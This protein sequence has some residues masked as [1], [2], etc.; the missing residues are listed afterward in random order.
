MRRI[1][2]A[3]PFV[4]LATAA[5]ANTVDCG[6]NSFS[7]AEVRTHPRGARSKGPAQ[8]V[9][10]SLCANLIE[11]RRGSIRSLDITLDPRMGQEEEAEEERPEPKRRHLRD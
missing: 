7:Y 4:C 2:M 3:L 9:P 1:A 6:G 10:D 11:R 5:G 8:V